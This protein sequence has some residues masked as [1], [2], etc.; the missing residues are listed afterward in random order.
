VN[1][2]KHAIVNGVPCLNGTDL[3]SVGGD[4]PPK[5]IHPYRAAY[6]ERWYDRAGA[7][8]H[9]CS[10]TSTAACPCKINFR[11]CPEFAIEC[12]LPRWSNRMT[13]AFLD[14]IIVALIPSMLMLAWLVWRMP[15]EGHLSDESDLPTRS[16]GRQV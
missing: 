4:M 6:F 15:S 3:P 10:V 7:Y 14:G 16:R 11:R 13:Q 9:T 2:L 12:P 5:D 1:G 8:Q